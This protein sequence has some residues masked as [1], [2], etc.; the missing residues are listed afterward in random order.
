MTVTK[1]I[2][3]KIFFNLKENILFIED[4]RSRIEEFKFILR[5]MDI[6]YSDKDLDI[7]DS[8]KV[9]SNLDIINKIPDKSFIFCLDKIRNTTQ[10]ISYSLKT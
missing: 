6:D 3:K 8:E 4:Y 9:R 10:E 1:K 5:K 2:Y 7:F